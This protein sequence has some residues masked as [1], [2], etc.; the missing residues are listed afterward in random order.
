MDRY[1]LIEI[2]VFERLGQSTNPHLL[3]THSVADLNVDHRVV[4]NAV[5][6]AQASA[7]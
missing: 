2:V 5:L 7:I 3:L 1:A 6:T 4:A